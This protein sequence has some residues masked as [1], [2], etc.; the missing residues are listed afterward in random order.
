M[1]EEGL[2]RTEP[3]CRSIRLP[4]AS[5]IVHVCTSNTL[6]HV[7]TD[8]SLHFLCYSFHDPRSFA[9][10]WKMMRRFTISLLSAMEAWD[11]DLCTPAVWS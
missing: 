7:L 10:V 11:C 1:G 4:S 2:E 5:T 3:V 6:L 8:I 9:T